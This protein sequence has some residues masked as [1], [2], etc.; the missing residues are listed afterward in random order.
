MT[1]ISEDQVF[2]ARL[3]LAGPFGH[4]PEVLAVRRF[5]RFVRLS[6]VARRF[7]VPAWQARVA[8]TLQCRELIR[9]I[10]EVDLSHENRRRADA[11]VVRMSC[12]ASA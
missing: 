12:A 6:S 8:T 4:I 9:A 10:R 3:A 5:K 2:A 1:R 7:E 11:A